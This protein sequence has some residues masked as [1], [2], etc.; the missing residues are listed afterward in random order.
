[1]A[2]SAF[3]PFSLG[4]RGCVGK[5]LAL[6][7]LALVLGRLVWSL[8]FKLAEVD[9]EKLPARLVGRG[10]EDEYQL[11]AGFTAAKDGPIVQFRRRIAV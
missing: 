10:P 8:D 5:S 11:L 2:R 4:A 3:I 1:M 9:N 7:E 6:K